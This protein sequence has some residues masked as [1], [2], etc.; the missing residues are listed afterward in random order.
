MALT[1]TSHAQTS[2]DALLDKLEQK[3]IL[4]VDEAKEL[5]SE[6]E[7]NSVNDFNAQ[8]NSKFPMPD[9]VESYT[10]YGD[11]RGYLDDISTET[12]VY[13]G[14]NGYV[15]GQYNNMRFRDRLRVGLT[16]DMKDN[17]QVG[18]RLGTDD[19]GNTSTGGNPLSNDSTFQGNGSKKYIYVDLAYGKWT[20][21]NNGTFML[22][23]TVGKMDQPFQ[24]S[25]MLFDPDYT[26]EGAALQAKYQINDDNSLV[27]NGGLFA[28]DQT[29][30]RSP[31]LYGGQ[32]I[33]NASWT[34]KLSTSLGIAGYNI[35][36]DSSFPVDTATYPYPYTTPY[37]SNLGNTTRLV[38][39]PTGPGII[40]PGYTYAYH[41]NPIVGSASTT[42]TL[43]HFPLFPI[44]SGAFPIK[45][46]GEYMKNPSAPANNVG[47]WGG[48]T[49]GKA[50]RK[51]AWDISY[52]YQRLEADAWW[53][54]IVDDD[55]T[56]VFPDPV[57]GIPPLNYAVGGTNI[58]GHLITFDYSILDSLTFTFTAYINDLINN[59]TPSD[60]TDAIHIMAIMMW[61][62]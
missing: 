60:S 20:P 53:D 24:A 32:M 21:I 19:P 9:W 15:K 34:R 57:G 37:D 38:E 12:P 47:W 2:V 23:G 51:G 3:G 46:A 39:V 16:I 30:S 33:W 61:K 18:F 58:K 52:R 45:F 56:A 50:G 49:L 59:P 29:T 22:S 41:Y 8:L 31:F 7:T 28:L 6:N 1:P 40:T 44:Y 55:N 26:P 11:F 36:N 48:V 27:A 10:F 17:M 62:F 42:Y 54:Q 35:A 5:K 25:P 43:D 13:G 4:T 14:P